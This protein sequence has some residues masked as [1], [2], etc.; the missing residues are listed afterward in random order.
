V[1]AEPPD[2]VSR[3]P[4]CD[5]RRRKHVAAVWALL[6][7]T[8]VGS[9]TA[10]SSSMPDATNGATRPGGVVVSTLA[11]DTTFHGAE[12]HPP[13]PMP[14]ISL[15]ATDGKP[16]NL[17]SDSASPVTLVFFGYTACPDVCPLVMSDLTAALLQ[18]PAQVRRSTRLLFITTDPARDSPAVLREYLDHYNH[19]FIGLTGP[20]RDIRAAGASLGVLIG[21]RHRSPGGGYEVMHGTQVIGFRG[22]EA[23]VVW[24]QGTSV[25]DLVE[26]LGRLVDDHPTG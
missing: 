22:N 10:C 4:G 23:R 18:S 6:A 16:Y 25:A 26:D 19:G 12:P 8:A 5:R 20:L 9:T 21:G 17:R 13:Y 14:D 7:V 24:T 11:D 2:R 15:T 3:R 1:S